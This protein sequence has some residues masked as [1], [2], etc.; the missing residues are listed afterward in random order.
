V[1]PY[2]LEGVL[3]HGVRRGPSPMITLLLVMVAGGIGVGLRFL[4]E[5]LVSAQSSQSF[6]WATL[7]INLLGAFAIGVVVEVVPTSPDAAMHVRPALAMG[8][9]GGFTTF[10]AF[11]LES[12]TLLETG[13]LL[14][15][16]IYIGATNVVG[17]AACA[18]G[19]LLGRSV[20]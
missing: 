18:G 9:L 8:L 14:R 19:L 3:A 20:M 1:D 6:P 2:E 5:G 10:S 17:I 13:E 7:L 4:I 12:I 16:G 15:A 11:A